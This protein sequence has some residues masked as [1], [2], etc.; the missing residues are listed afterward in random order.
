MSKGVSGFQRNSD[1]RRNA[2][3]TEKRLL[4]GLILSLPLMLNT[5]QP[6]ARTG[7]A[8]MQAKDVQKQSVKITI[9]DDGFEPGSFELKQ[10]V[11]A[12]VTFLRESEVSCAK[13]V[14]IPVFHIKRA[15]PLNEAVVVEFTPDKSGEFGF[16]CG[17]GMLH[18]KLVVK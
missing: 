5:L 2:M 18:G 14:V 17:M 10:G 13:E 8:P 1:T 15:L 12:R 11:L 16:A 9:T 4:V 7:A 6:L 3:T